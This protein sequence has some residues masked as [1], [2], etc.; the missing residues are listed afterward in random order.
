[1]RWSR[2][3]LAYATLTAC[4]P[5]LL[6]GCDQHLEPPAQRGE[7]LVAVRETPAFYEEVNG[8]AR[9]FDHD[10]VE[11]F[12]RD[13]GVS[14]RFVVA[15]GHADLIRLVKQ[16]SVHFAADAPLDA[17][18]GLRYSTVLRE[19]AQLIVRYADTSPLD[20]ANALAGKRIEV[21]AGSPQLDAL[22][23]L[24]ALGN[25]RPPFVIAARD[26]MNEI[27]LLRRISQKESE[28][29]ATDTTHFKI[30][31]NF[32]PELEEALELEGKVRFA[33][34]FASNSD[35]HLYS[36]AEEFIH[37]IHQDGTLA[38]I[39]DRYFGHIH[40]LNSEGVSDFLERV[41]LVLPRFRGEFIAA[42]ELTGVDWRLLASLS[43][44]ESRWDPLATSPTGVRG[45]M[46][47]TED[48]ADQLNVK[49]RLD[50]RQS[51]RAG[52]KYL[53]ELIEQVP[54]EVREPDRT[55]LALAAYNLGQGHMNGARAIA[56]G[57]KRDPNSWYEMKQVLPLLSRQKYYDRLKSGRARGGEAVIMVE[58]VR[59]FNDILSRFEPAYQATHYSPPIFSIPPM[60]GRSSSG[61]ATLPLPF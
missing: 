51:I 29:A 31:T 21:L 32:Y 19:S 35:V 30:G 15:R 6:S 53:A 1:M 43:Y 33:W 40:R 59:T 41:A 2:R 45:M 38:R 44:Q 61:T 26:D 27:D 37:R 54:P 3:P 18:P 17:D 55:W 13:L 20:D 16:G 9:G 52:A 7:L 10:L 23:A 25:V 14:P 8:T 57:L 48:T 4:L 36:R 50:A 22:Q 5:L 49:N 24:L 58:N 39:H 46:M 42:Q 60:Y 11:R 12:A 34:A 47:L 28:L 56:T